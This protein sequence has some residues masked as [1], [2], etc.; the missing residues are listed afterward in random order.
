MK[1]KIEKTG[2][3]GEGI[4]YLNN[5][6]IFIPSALPGET[7]EAEI[8][9]KKERFSNG[10]LLRIVEA[11]PKRIEAP[12]EDQGRCGGL[13]KFRLINKAKN[14]IQFLSSA[15]QEQFHFNIFLQDIR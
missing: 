12:C 15:A 14:L 3:N 6:P 5:K 8:I 11:S 10:E 2:I 9:E 7:I 4:G 13:L 1:I